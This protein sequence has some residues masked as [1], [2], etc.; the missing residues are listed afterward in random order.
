MQQKLFHLKKK[1]K[2]KNPNKTH[3][4]KTKNLKNPHMITFSLNIEF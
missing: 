3:K 2:Q 4:N 1:T